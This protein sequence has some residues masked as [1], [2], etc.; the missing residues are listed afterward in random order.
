MRD[1]AS[2]ANQV[3]TEERSIGGDQALLTVELAVEAISQVVEAGTQSL[4][5]QV[6]EEMAQTLT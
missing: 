4:Y 3:V 6:T 1:Q 5:P 2:D